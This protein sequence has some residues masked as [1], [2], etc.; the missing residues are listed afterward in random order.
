LEQDWH[1]PIF[2]TIDTMPIDFFAFF[3]A[4][5]TSSTS[6]FKEKWNAIH[7]GLHFNI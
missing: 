3:G 6:L 5:A 2:T 7:I 4:I 1:C